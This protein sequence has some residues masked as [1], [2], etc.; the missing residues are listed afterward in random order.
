MLLEHAHGI[1]NCQATMQL[2][3]ISIAMQKWSK[4]TLRRGRSAFV[5]ARM[6]CLTDCSRRSHSRSI[7]R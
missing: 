7:W 1:V 6:L 2:C 3:V 5:S 4:R